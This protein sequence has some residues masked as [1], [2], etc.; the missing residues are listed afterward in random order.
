MVFSI[1]LK[2]EHKEFLENVLIPLHKATTLM[3]FSAQL[4]Y[5]I[6]QFVAKDASLTS[7]ILQGLLR[8]WPLQSSQKEV[9]FLTEIEAIL[10]IVEH[11]ALDP[12]VEEVFDRLGMCMCSV[13]FQ[14]SE[15]A[16]NLTAN[17]TISYYITRQRQRIVPILYPYLQKNLRSHWH[18]TV[19]SVTVNI[20]ATLRE[21]DSGLYKKIVLET[22]R[23]RKEEEERSARREDRWAKLKRSV[24]GS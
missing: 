20:L 12:V 15:Q 16:L 7:D 4:N 24:E 19:R 1:P 11:D 17:E 9:L 3:D 18:D 23:S 2:T 14:V 10:D 6:T 13:H 21:M 8:Y 22:K 5:C